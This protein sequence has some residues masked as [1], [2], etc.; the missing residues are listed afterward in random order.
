MSSLR[1]TL[2]LLLLATLPQTVHA[3][4]VCTA[5]WNRI[6]IG[7][8]KNLPFTADIAFSEWKLS[9]DGTQKQR[10]GP[11]FV[12]HAARDSTGKV[13]IRMPAGWTEGRSPEHGDEATYWYS[14]I[15]SPQDQ[16]TTWISKSNAQIDSCR[17]GIP[18]LMQ[19][20]GPAFKFPLVPS[21]ISVDSLGIKDFNG[22][23][24]SGF[25][26]ARE[27]AANSPKIEQWLSDSMEIE[28][29]HTETDPLNAIE[30]QAVVLNFRPQEAPSELF[31]I[32][33]EL[34]DK[35]VKRSCPAQ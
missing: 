29:S 13:V 11:S 3:E 8:V 14:T 33:P 35:V 21:K 22:I 9:A 17:G 32:P 7:L 6:R 26:Y 34:K 28:M 30:T 20:H 18:G 25:R 2:W 5:Q 24:A 31:Q 16:T 10:N 27:N 1:P 15:C 19:I 4:L 23:Q 12:A